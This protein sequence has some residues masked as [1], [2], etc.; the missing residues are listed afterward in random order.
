MIRFISDLLLLHRVSLV[1][2]LKNKKS[3][4]LKYFY[5]SKLTVAFDAL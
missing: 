5:T 1:F 4:A 2:V 3:N